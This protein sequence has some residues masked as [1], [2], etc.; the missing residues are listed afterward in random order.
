MLPVVKEYYNLNARCFA[1]GFWLA[2]Q[3]VTYNMG[4]WQW[5]CFMLAWW[6]IAIALYGS[7]RLNGD[8]LGILFSSYKSLVEELGGGV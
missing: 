5:W 8:W 4:G 2:L 3:V 6:V 1:H 7:V